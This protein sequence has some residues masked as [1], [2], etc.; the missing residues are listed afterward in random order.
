MT[1]FGAGHPINVR[2]ILVWNVPHVPALCNPLYSLCKHLSQR[3]C[4]FIGDESLGGLFVYLSSLSLSAD[5]TTD[6][7]LSYK[8]VGHNITLNG[9]DYVEPKCALKA[10]AAVKEPA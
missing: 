6:C 9:I 10:L 2:L 3:G 8:P 1:F 7:H 4:G 5:T